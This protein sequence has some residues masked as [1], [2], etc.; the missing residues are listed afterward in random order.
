MNPDDE[1]L[2]IRERFFKRLFLASDRLRSFLEW[3]IRLCRLFFI[4]TLILFLITFLYYIGFANSEETI[5]KLRSAFKSFFFILFLSKYLPL[6]F[7]LREKSLRSLVFEILVFL[8]AFFVFISNFNIVISNNAFWTFFFGN[9]ALNGAIFII[10]ISEISGFARLISSINIPPALLFSISFFIIIITGAG[11]LLLPEAHTQS[12]TFLNS[13]FTSVSAVCVT[14][15]VVVDTATSFTP[16]GKIIILCLIQIGGLGIMT[17]TGFFSYIF[18][19]SSSFRDRLLLKEIFSSQSLENLFKLLTKIILWTFL[20]EIAGAFLIYSSLDMDSKNKIFFSIFH[21]ISAFCNA[22]FSTLSDGLFSVNIRH[23]Y[24]VQIIIALLVILGGIGFPVLL[25]IYSYFKHL[26]VVLIRTVLRKRIPVMHVQ[27]NISGRIVIFMTMLLI[28]AGTVLYF[29]FES[30]NSLNGMDNTRKIIISFF[31][32]VSARTAGFHVTDISL[33]GYPTIF[34]MILLMWIGASPGSTG[35]GIKTTTFFIAFRSAFNSIKGRH[36]LEIGNR[37]IGSGTIIR[38][39][40]IIFLSI[41]IITA[42]FFCLLLSEP[43]KN[44]VHLFFE[45]VSAFG[46]VGLSLANTSSFSQTG[47]IVVILLMFIGRVGPLTLLTG[48]LVSYRKSYSRYPETDIII[49]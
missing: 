38:V 2:K 29:I 7:H 28:L 30:E 37:E 46:T 49:N 1:N 39:S 23:N 45:C 41:L 16:L 34:L 47:K 20:T 4:L 14:G 9:K 10:A 18:A 6:I 22:G 43:G 19:S 17:F 33:W 8:F 13:L 12:L 35:G 31:G 5:L 25:N 27:M 44:P 32:S 40:S 48:L 15:L 36:Y 42:G 11:L 3:F 21:A 26:I 24:S